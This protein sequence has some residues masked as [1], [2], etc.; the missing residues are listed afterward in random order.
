MTNEAICDK[1]GEAFG[2][3]SADGH[4][5]STCPSCLAEG[6]E[7]LAHVDLGYRKRGRPRVDP[8]HR[9]KEKLVLSLTADELRSVML[10]AA[11]ERPTPLSPNDWARRE[12]L[13]LAT[14][15]LQEE[16]K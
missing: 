8:D 1:C 4:V 15:P 5:G 12:L 11:N 2:G 7:S 16:G 13:R 14:P 6:D 3:D 9:R 10:K